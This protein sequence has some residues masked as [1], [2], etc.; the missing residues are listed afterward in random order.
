MW[1][2]VGAVLIAAAVIAALSFVV[3]HDAYVAE[4]ERVLHDQSISIARLAG[5][6]ADTQRVALE[7]LHVM[8]GQARD[9]ASHSPWLVAAL[10]IATATLDRA[11]TF[12]WVFSI[13]IAAGAMIIS[14]LVS[15]AVIAAL[16]ICGANRFQ[17]C[18]RRVPVATPV[19][20]PPSIGQVVAMKTGY[21]DDNGGGLTPK[22]MPPSPS[23]PLPP[24]RPA[25]PP[26]KLAPPESVRAGT[27]PPAFTAAA[28]A[29]P[30][31]GVRLRRR[32][33][34]PPPIG[35]NGVDVPT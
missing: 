31:A 29:R 7:H 20:L 1:K 35:V 13:P 5:S 22:A 33:A 28:S 17:S 14:A 25:T 10:R 21:D 9:E 26:K 4:Y 2:N 34:S 19:D 11:V 18:R 12:M 32:T 27:A 16:L 15:V 30:T 23:P 8:C 6:C 3:F 24:P